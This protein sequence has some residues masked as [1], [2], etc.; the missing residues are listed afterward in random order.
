MSHLSGIFPSVTDKGNCVHTWVY[1]ADHRNHGEPSS[2]DQHCLRCGKTIRSFHQPGT[3]PVEINF[4][5]SSLTRNQQ[6]RLGL[7]PPPPPRQAYR[8]N[9]MNGVGSYRNL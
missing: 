8:E 4:S 1:L 5:M 3:S 2:T 9:K 6:V 7:V